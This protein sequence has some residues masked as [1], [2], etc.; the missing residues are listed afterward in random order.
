MSY[1][2]RDGWHEAIRKELRVMTKAEL[3]NGMDVLKM[4]QEALNREIELLQKKLDSYTPPPPRF[5][6]IGDRCPV[7]SCRGKLEVERWQS[8]EPLDD[9]ATHSAWYVCSHCGVRITVSK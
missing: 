1:P 8:S 2:F 6:D 7:R 3:Q 9:K 5:V 4:R